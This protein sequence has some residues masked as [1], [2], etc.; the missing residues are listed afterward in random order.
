MCMVIDKSKQS[1]LQ[2]KRKTTV[3]PNVF[4][5]PAC[6]PPFTSTQANYALC[7]TLQ[8]AH[9]KWDLTIHC[10]YQWRITSNF[11]VK[12]LLEI[13]TH[14]RFRA[15][16]RTEHDAVCV[17]WHSSCRE[18]LLLE[19]LAGHDARQSSCKHRHHQF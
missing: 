11:L 9:G 14:F 18:E 4:Q 13:C 5:F 6:V 1:S 17:H 16:S 3:F 8:Q 10:L 7:I 15:R 12:C 19:T 2:R